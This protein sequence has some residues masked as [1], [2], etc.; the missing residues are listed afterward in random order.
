MLRRIGI[1]LLAVAALASA[2][3]GIVSR[4]RSLI[5]F[6]DPIVTPTWW[7]LYTAQADRGV[8]RVSFESLGSF[9][10]I[11]EADM[12][13]GSP[14][15]HGLA[16][17]PAMTFW[18]RL[19]LHGF[20]R[21]WDASWSYGGGTD[22]NGAYIYV[23]AMRRTLG[24]GGPAWFWTCLFGFVPAVA[25]IRRPSRR[26]ELRRKLGLCVKCGYDLRGLPEPRCPECGTQIMGWSAA[27]SPPG[28]E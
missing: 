7:K 11:T 1:V 28:S 21:N 9:E 14:F 22:E 5:Y 25:M 8:L 6:C 16:R 19:E 17:P 24:F 4:N 23:R 20:Y 27:A 13:N 3:L 18:R 2:A 15:G 10:V 12:P 26:R